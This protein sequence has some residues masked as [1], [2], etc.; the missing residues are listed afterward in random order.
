MQ[1]TRENLPAV[2]EIAFDVLRNPAFPADEFATLKDNAI[3]SIE[4]QRSE[5]DAI[6][7]LALERHLGQNYE[8]GDP[9]YTETF[10]ESIAELNAVDVA[11]LRAFHRDFLG[12]SNAHV[13][14]VGDFDP[15]MFAAA[16]EAGLAD[17]QSPE[18][19]QIVTPYPDPVPP[20][21]NE[22]FDTPDKENAYFLAALPIRMNNEDEDYAA[23]V[24]G[25]YILG[26]GAG[27]R[28][29]A[30]IRGEEGLSYGAYASFGAP[31]LADGAQLV[32]QAIAAPENI[33]QVEASF[34]DEMTT[35]LREGYTA[36]EIEAGKRSWAQNRQVGRAQD[37][38]LVGQLES[39]MH[40]GRTMQWDADLEARVQALTPE[41]VRDAMR[42]HIDL[43]ALTIMKG[44]DF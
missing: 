3:A 23:M 30:R 19:T 20:P 24:L 35:I 2:L 15:E 17:W 33:A 36:E 7:G 32:A 18:Y 25:A 27:S 1:S 29:F 9:R 34:L 12:A 16:I 40:Y 26:D 39:H 28:L 13:V 42:R 14:V 5:P 21:V 41:Q 44:G 37:G 11:D 22:S 38:S 10:D 31:S 6:A 4:S 43:D 8:R